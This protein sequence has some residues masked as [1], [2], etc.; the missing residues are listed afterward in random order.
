[1]ILESSTGKRFYNMDINL[2][3]ER[4]WN[5]LYLTPKQFQNDIEQILHDAKQEESDR[6]RVLKAQEMH[7]NVLIHL[8]DMFDTA[9]LEECKGMALREIERH[10]NY[11]AAKLVAES[12][13]SN[14]AQVVEEQANILVTPE[15]PISES[16]LNDRQA[17]E[18]AEVN[19]LIAGINTTG[20][21]SN[22][23]HTLAQDAPESSIQQ[24]QVQLPT[25]SLS[26]PQG[27]SEDTTMLDGGHSEIDTGMSN[28]RVSPML[29]STGAPTAQSRN[30]FT[31]PSA[32]QNA[33]PID[34]NNHIPEVPIDLVHSPASSEQDVQ[35]NHAHQEYE[36]D[37]TR[38]EALRSNWVTLTE[39]ANVDQL[40]HINSK[41]VEA[42]W[43]RRTEWNR[44]EAAAAADQAIKEYVSSKDYTSNVSMMQ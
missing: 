2:I 11:L 19:E 24:E 42:I 31:N 41:A 40:E 5:T 25:E 18:D 33:Q 30:A 37:S 14:Q 13:P 10:R 38:L 23:H 4:L 32:Q 21:S 26:E 7:T 36:L 8:E 29:S 15:M 20:E 28:G 22:I 35:E 44:N 12:V 3:E 34:V 6:E 27:V 9:F 43:T 16:L 39:R 17:Q 1:M